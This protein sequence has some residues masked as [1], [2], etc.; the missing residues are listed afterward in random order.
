[1]F[2]RS[3]RG[4]GRG[5]A[6]E[7]QSEAPF[8]AAFMVT[9]TVAVFIFHFYYQN[10]NWTA[11]LSVSMIV[12]GIT[13]LRVELGVFILVLSMLLSPEINAGVVGPAAERA[14]NIRY[15]DILILVI[16]AGVVVK[17]GFE[18]GGNLWCRSPANTGIFAY[19]L[20]CVISTLFALQRSLPAW[21][22]NTA[23]FVM[24]KML[25]F[26]MVF[27]LVG[28]AI[29]S[30]GEIENQLKAFFLVAVI[31]SIYATYSIRTLDRVSA[32]FE[33]GGTE[34][35]T[36]G[37]YLTIVMCLAS[38]L[39]VHAPTRRKKFLFL[40][41][42]V[43]AFVPFLYTLSRASYF[44]FTV[45]LA[46]L[47]LLSKRFV[48]I[49]LIGA[50]LVASPLLMPEKVKERV[51]MTF[52]GEPLIIGGR[53]TGLTADKST[54]E[55]IHVWRKARHTLR[56]SPWYG[57]GIS[58]ETVLDSQY[59]RVV[60]E[61]GLLGFAAFLY[62]LYRLMLTSWQAYKWSPHWVGR[63]V[64]LGTLAATVGMAV[65]SLGTISFLIVRI[66]MPFWYLMAL[67]AV[68]RWQAIVYHAEKELEQPPAVQTVPGQAI[69]Q[70][71]MR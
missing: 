64:A 19:Y 28:R 27:I 67:T 59:A 10:L 34:P 25:E 41:L 21:D 35:N 16:F 46:V 12:F 63:G 6:P 44:S 49:L 14:L 54:Q 26:Y 22:R 57:G 56:W 58:W 69:P 23:F 1:M 15:D 52:I 51:N 55:R 3:E 37:G 30:L 36:L 53:D 2:F 7:S 29:R 68:V 71:V 45:G 33:Q 62:M 38:G 13:I 9:C 66:M 50:V 32:P 60:I 42:A 4:I 47:A 11:A 61:T 70:P 20:V 43:S 18:G 65:H 31:V 5:E 17:L 40:M 39:F 48:I 8:F 24:L